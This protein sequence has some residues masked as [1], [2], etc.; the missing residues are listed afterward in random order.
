MYDESVRCRFG[1]LF[2]QRGPTGMLIGDM[3]ILRL[4]IYVQH[5][6]EEKLRD[7]EKYKNKKE[8]TANESGP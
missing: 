3:E 4:M 2:K 7:R 8:K 6:E 1:S 5:V